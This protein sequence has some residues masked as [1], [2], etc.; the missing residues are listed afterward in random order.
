MLDTSPTVNAGNLA[1]ANY[2]KKLI[3]VALPLQAINAAAAR[4]KSIPQGHPAGLHVWWARRPLAACRAV[5][6]ASLVDDPSSRPDKFPTIQEQDRERRRLFDL[7]EQL[8]QWENSLNEDVLAAARNE[9]SRSGA[10]GAKIY[11]PFCGGGAIPIEAQRLGLHAIASDLN[12]VAAL[13]TRCLADVPSRFAGRGPVSYSRDELN[14]RG[15]WVRAM[16]LATDVETYGE[17]LIETARKRLIDLYPTVEIDGGAATVIAWLWA[18]TVSC[19]NPICGATIPLVKTFALST[20][21]N[22]TWCVDVAVDHARRHTAFSVRRGAPTCDGTVN[23]RG[24]RCL[25]CEEAA[26]L[27]YVR[28]EGKKQR[29]GTRML[30]IVAEGRRGRVYASP[31]EQHEHIASS[32]EPAWEPDADIVNNPRHMSPPLYGMTRYADLFTRRQLNLLT[33]LSDLVG[34]MRARVLG[35]ALASGVPDDGVTL[36]QGGSGGTAYA[37][38]IAAYLA[39]FVDRVASRSSSQCWW[40]RGWEKVTNVF[41]RQTLSIVWDFAESN[42]FSESTGNVKRALESV[43]GTVRCAYAKGSSKVFV[44]DATD[45]ASYP[46]AVVCTDPPYYDNVPYA[47]LSDFFYTWL[48]TALSGVF[49][50]LF[51]TVATPKM[52]ELVADPMRFGGDKARARSFFE[53]GLERVFTQI[54][55][56]ASSSAPMTVFYAFKQTDQMV[57]GETDAPEE[58]VSHGWETMLK[59]LLA[60][61]FEITGTWPITTEQPVRLRSMNSNALA[62][63]IILVCR[64]RSSGSV[65]SRSEFVRLLRLELPTAIQRLREASLAPTDLQQAALG[66]GM[67][68]FSRYATVLEPDDSAMTVRSALALINEQLG[69]T[70]LGEIGDVDAESHFALAWFDE[71]GY[72]NGRYARADVL[73]R[74]KNANIEKLVRSGV[75]V[76]ESGN[77]RLL[78]PQEVT[79][80][81]RSALRSY[82]SWSQGIHVIAALIGIDGSEEK[83]AAALRAIGVDASEHIKDIAYHCYLVCDRARRST[84]ARDF[85]AL[86]QA[87]PDLLRLASE[88]GGDTL[89]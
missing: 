83:A 71:L 89:F 86:V 39:L 22:N 57:I 1:Q 40:E 74:A 11:D 33:T 24:V 75:A 69:Q 41:A 14:V 61:G 80:E 8:V 18:R 32:V 6:F 36:E 82:P 13:L 58:R 76:S 50:E 66:P 60:A 29:L 51:T 85:N 31:N 81:T 27:A 28:D 20:R 79:Q 67:S 26:S 25:V 84:E 59:A 42:P 78:S 5:I 23:R 73:L 7:M 52:Q 56:N 37:D 43:V 38:A 54:R 16:G 55:E 35:D 10:G 68:I 34:E 64:P 77:V 48:R 49:P 44:R 9:I 19:P 3:E 4:E 15:P 87:W 17:E 45:G 46:D 12:P 47:D 62:S 88:H 70:L 63:S 2:R 53:D 21:Q 72:S 65:C 30:A